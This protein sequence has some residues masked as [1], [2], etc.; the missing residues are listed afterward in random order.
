M[1][2]IDRRILLGAVLILVLVPILI[3]PRTQVEVKQPPTPDLLATAV[4]SALQSENDELATQVAQ[5]DPARRPLSMESDS[6]TIRRKLQLSF[7][8][9]RTIQ[10]EGLVLNPTE[11]SGSSLRVDELIDQPRRRFRVSS[12]P[13]DETTELLQVSDGSTLLLANVNTGLVQSN[14][15]PAAVFSSLDPIDSSNSGPQDHPLNLVI[16]SPLNEMVLPVGLSQQGGYYQG[17]RME[18]VAGRLALVVRWVPGDALRDSR[19]LWIDAQTGVVL[20]SATFGTLGDVS[21]IE[22]IVLTSV[23]FD[24]PLQPSLFDLES[25]RADVER[26]A[27]DSVGNPQTQTPLS[28]PQ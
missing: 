22:D 23:A 17:L 1:V 24:V 18:E 6:E 15:L 12:G 5:L 13:V 4:I 21:P 27:G 7:T 10:L 3:A 16:H 2:E 26:M 9:W 8:N 25:I 19:R 28:A 20:R 14:P 11:E